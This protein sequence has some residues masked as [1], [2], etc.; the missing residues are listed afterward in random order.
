ML[1]QLQSRFLRG[2]TAAHPPAALLSI[3]QGVARL[4]APSGAFIAATTPERLPEALKQHK[5]GLLHVV[6]VGGDEEERKD[7]KKGWPNW[8]A[9]RQFAFHHLDELGDYYHV[10][11]PKLALIETAACRVGTL[12]PLS[13]EEAA[14]LIQA[15]RDLLRAEDEFSKTA[16]MPWVSLAIFAVCLITFFLQEFWGGSKSIFGLVRMGANPGHAAFHAPW[17][18]L[19]SAFLHIGTAHL[20]LNMAALASF[21]PLLEKALGSGRF[22]LLY[23]GSALGGSLLSAIGHTELVSAGASGALWGL[24]VG[25]A[26]LI[27]RPQGALPPLMVARMKT[28]VW[29]PVILNGIYSLQPGID[30]LCHFGGGLV[31]GGLVASGVL[32]IGLKR[33]RSQPSSGLLRA[34]VAAAAAACLA[35]LGTAWAVGHPWELGQ[36]PPMERQFAGFASLSLELPR[37]LT[38]ERESGAVVYGSLQHDPIAVELRIGAAPK[39]MSADEMAG[40]LRALSELFRK[41]VPEGARLIGNVRETKIAGAPGYQVDAKFANEVTA[42]MWGWVVPEGALLL[43]IYTSPDTPSSWEHIGETIAQSVRTTA[44]R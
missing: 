26:A 10:K 33:D 20:V 6:L 27:T 40:E 1:D 29:Q 4:L 22:L 12:D 17:T 31:G 14:Q 38:E 35:S 24:M 44:E 11:G 8:Q 9:T 34:A 19:A 13:Q 3:D 5:S 42:H 41:K 32:L 43:R 28:R 37:G 15:S 2:L 23:V 39:P 21:G 25:G 36:L 30:W 7:L 18:L 16:G